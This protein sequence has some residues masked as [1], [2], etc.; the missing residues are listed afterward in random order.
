MHIRL[1]TQLCKNW[2][3]NERWELARASSIFVATETRIA[4][5]LFKSVCFLTFFVE[6]LA[7]QE[8]IHERSDIQT[9]M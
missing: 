5:K 6:F 4:S 7:H 9:E 1:N 2:R 3:L 8:D